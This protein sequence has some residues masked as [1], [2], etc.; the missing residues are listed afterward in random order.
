MLNFQKIKVSDFEYIYNDLVSQFPITELKGYDKLYNLINS[1]N[2]DGWLIYD[3]SILIGYSFIFEGLNYI[4]VD[5]VAILK[6]FHS[7]GYGS[8]F[9]KSLRSLYSNKAGCFFEVEKVIK[10]DPVTKK[11]AD[12][13][14]KN[15]VRKI[16]SINYIYPNNYGGLPMDLYYLS[17]NNT[18]PAKTE[19]KNFIYNF[20]SLV[21]DDIKDIN[22]IYE[23]I[24]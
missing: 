17:F 9:L 5:Y 4:L 14:I 2:Y 16:E 7:K 3:E 19:I 23:K 13:Y 1:D 21:H 24:T 22:K 18:L 6:D 8:S 10:N 15:S 11:R 12:F 20:F